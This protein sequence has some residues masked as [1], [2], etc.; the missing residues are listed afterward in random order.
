[1]NKISGD[2]AI[3]LGTWDWIYTDH[4]YGWCDGDSWFEVLTPMTE[5]VEFT[6]EFIEQGLVFFYK[7]DSM[8][9]E[10]RISFNYVKPA[11]PGCSLTTSELL[12]NI[13]LDGLKNMSCC[14]SADSM[15]C[16]FSGF[17]FKAEQGCES[18][19]NFFLKQ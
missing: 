5:E 8:I 19:T 3:V 1:M 15:T 16:S 12:I 11:P 13:N 10:Q 7:N 17:I 9:S 2:T 14:V 4:D 18:Y 6:L